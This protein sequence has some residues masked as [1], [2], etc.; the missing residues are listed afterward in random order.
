MYQAYIEQLLEMGLA[1]LL[2]M[3]L[4]KLLEMRLANEH[5]YHHF[6]HKD[7]KMRHTLRN[8]MLDIL[9][10]QDHNLQDHNQN[11]KTL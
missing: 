7:Y 11:H 9:H 2:E 8:E 6:R 10:L 5:G 3:R 1:K 4:A